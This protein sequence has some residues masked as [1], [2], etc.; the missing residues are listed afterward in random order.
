MAT[1][2]L[3]S[4]KD[5]HRCSR[6]TQPIDSRQHTF[7][8]KKIYSLGKTC[9]PCGR[10]IG[11][12]TSCY[13]CTDCKAICHMECKGKV[14]VP[15]IAV[16]TPNSHMK[17]GRQV[18][19]ADF[20]PAN[21]RPRIPALIVHCCKEIERRGLSEKGIYRIP[22]SIKDV[23]SLKD[24]ILNSKTGMPSLRNVDIHVICSCVKDFLRSLD[25][26]LTTRTLWRDFVS[27]ASMENFAEVNLFLLQ[28][29][30]ELPFANRDTLAYLML[31]LQK[32]ASSPAC[33]MPITNLSRI[34]GPTIVGNTVKDPSPWLFSNEL[35]KQQQVVEALLKIPTDDWNVLINPEVD[36]TEVSE[37]AQ[38]RKSTMSQFRGG[39]ITVGSL[40]PMR[41][42]IN[43]G[44]FKP[45]F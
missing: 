3:L 5:S 36:E 27:A 29:I 19:I 1:T 38:K 17:S 39:S 37:M 30:D 8:S 40:T 11:F 2:P 41:Y 16:V 35:P 33:K 24:Q 13:I 28:A 20:V 14:P 25:E 18:L 6:I 22:G 43:S 7:V 15:C 4:R 44:L 12:C 34:F 26:Q 42:K 23:K 10:P 9:G 32:V 31:H 21:T 45:L